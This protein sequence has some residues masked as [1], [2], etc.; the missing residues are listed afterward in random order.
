MSS[1][2]GD[3]DLIFWNFS[4]K[5]FKL[6]KKLAN[7]ELSSYCRVSCTNRLLA[8]TGTDKNLKIWSISP[9]WGANKLPLSIHLL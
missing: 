3:G 9:N 6:Y 2:G 5:D 4:E 1:G 7:H 8:T